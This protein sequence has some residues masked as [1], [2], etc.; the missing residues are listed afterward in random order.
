MFSRIK[1]RI[2][3]AA[4]MHAAGKENITFIMGLRSRRRKMVMRRLVE[5]AITKYTIPSRK[6]SFHKE[7]LPGVRRRPIVERINTVRSNPIAGEPWMST[8]RLYSGRSGGVL[9]RYWRL[10]HRLFASPVETSTQALTSGSNTDFT[11]TPLSR[12]HEYL[13]CHDLD[14]GDIPWNNIVQ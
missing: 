10:S 9:K 11:T 6:R 1:E 4:V 2:A 14:Y 5:N 3:A 13:D 8:H 7:V 12:S